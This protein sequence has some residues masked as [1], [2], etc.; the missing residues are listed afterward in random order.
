MSV[1]SKP[2][3]EYLQELN[4]QKY[5]EE[6]L[7]SQRIDLA[8]KL[9]ICPNCGSKLL[10]QSIFQCIFEFKKC[11]K[12]KSKFKFIDLSTYDLP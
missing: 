5:N 8:L 3:L 6:A 1:N 2:T 12:C 4:K 7:E 9:D 10:P 11:S